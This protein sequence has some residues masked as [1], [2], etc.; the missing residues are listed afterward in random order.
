MIAV[1]DVLALLGGFLGSVCSVPQL[2][3]MFRSG[4]AK[5]ISALFTSL[6]FISLALQA[7]YMTMK[8]AWAGAIALWIETALAFIFFSGKLYFLLMEK[9]RENFQ[10]KSIQ[11]SEITMEVTIDLNELAKNLSNTLLMGLAQHPSPIVQ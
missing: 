5:D 3:L 2:F 6:Y 1:A 8:S 9:Q 10:E 4:S 11:D 7:T